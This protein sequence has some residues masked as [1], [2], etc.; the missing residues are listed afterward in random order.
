MSSS[1][2]MDSKEE[3]LETSFVYHKC[4]VRLL[5]AKLHFSDRHYA[6]Q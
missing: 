6:N 4:V 2:T 1:D 5:S 3:E